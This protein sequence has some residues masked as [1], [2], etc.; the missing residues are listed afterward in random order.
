[1]KLGDLPEVQ[2]EVLYLLSCEITT[3]KGNKT[4]GAEHKSIITKYEQEWCGPDGARSRIR[5]SLNA[6]QERTPSGKADTKEHQEKIKFY[7]RDIRKYND[8]CA[9]IAN[10][11]DCTFVNAAINRGLKNTCGKAFGFGQHAMSS[12]FLLGLVCVAMAFSSYEKMKHEPKVDYGPLEYDQYG[13]EDEQNALLT[14]GADS[15]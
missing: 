13:A 9:G 7:Q 15:L 3:M 14:N 8:L 10:L 2:S 4:A 11:K 12:S 6:E 5:A 1:M